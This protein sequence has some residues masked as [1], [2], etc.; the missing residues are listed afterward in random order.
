[1]GDPTPKQTSCPT[2]GSTDVLSVDFQ[3][4]A[5]WCVCGNLYCPE[6]GQEMLPVIDNAEDVTH[7]EALK[8]P[9]C[10]AHQRENVRLR[11][12]RLRLIKGG[13]KE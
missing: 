3:G 4:R 12:Q 11:R 7:D 2:C 6:C 10:T 13:G 9:K 8:A 5:L 1:M